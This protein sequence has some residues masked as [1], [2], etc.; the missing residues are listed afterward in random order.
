M[1]VGSLLTSSATEFVGTCSIIISFRKLH[2]TRESCVIMV[3]PM[4]FR[5]HWKPKRNSGVEAEFPVRT[6]VS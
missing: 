4:I 1:G 3:E 2:S 6:L 5:F